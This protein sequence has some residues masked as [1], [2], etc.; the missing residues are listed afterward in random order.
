MPKAEKELIS[1]LISHMLLDLLPDRSKC[2]RS[3][4]EIHI[5]S[6]KL[7]YHVPACWWQGCCLSFHVHPSRLPLTAMLDAWSNMW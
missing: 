4:P 1:G 3:C 7:H 2:S 6:G 5:I